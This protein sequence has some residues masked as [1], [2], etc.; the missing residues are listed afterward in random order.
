M[1]TFS[2]YCG[3]YGYN[4]IRSFSSISLKKNHFNLIIKLNIKKKYTLQHLLDAL[5]VKK[6]DVYN[7]A[8]N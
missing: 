6:H 1:R 8:L 2:T 3:K 7:I 5:A 4:N